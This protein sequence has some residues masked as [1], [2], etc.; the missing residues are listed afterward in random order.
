MSE[1]PTPFQQQVYDACLRIPRGKVCSYADLAR[2]IDCASPRAVGQALKRNPF[3]P[4]VP[5]HRVVKTDRALGGFTGHRDG[6]EVA[7]KMKLLT[8]E[9]VQFDSDGRVS[10]ESFWKPA[11]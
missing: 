2:E 10:A 3:A 5:C 4:R 6:P 1:S 11:E 9:G 7:R 8:S